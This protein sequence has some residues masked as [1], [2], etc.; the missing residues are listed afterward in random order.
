MQKEFCK[1]CLQDKPALYDYCRAGGL[2]PIRVAHG[3]VM[4]TS[5]QTQ[6]YLLCGDCEDVLNKGGESW[7]NRELA[8]MERKFPFYDLLTK[9]PPEWE[10]DGMALYLVA[11]NS[12]IEVH[13]LAHFALGIFWKASVHSWNKNRV[14]AKIELGP[15]F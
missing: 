4:P 5:R 9:C 2:N 6:D 8:S 13:K 3:V 12:E 10:E 7:S 11:H 15:V 14:S 1:L